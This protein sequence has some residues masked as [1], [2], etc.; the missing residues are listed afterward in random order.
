MPRNVAAPM[1]GHRHCSLKERKQIIM[2]RCKNLKRKMRK[3][4]YKYAYRMFYRGQDSEGWSRG[5]FLIHITL[6][7]VIKLFFWVYICKESIS[8]PQDTAHYLLGLFLAHPFAKDWKLNL[9][10]V[11]RVCVTNWLADFKRSLFSYI[12]LLNIFLNPKYH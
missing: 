8:Y 6:T 7:T 12:I 9:A 2:D 4:D 11:W 1:A 10:N 5:R 3:P